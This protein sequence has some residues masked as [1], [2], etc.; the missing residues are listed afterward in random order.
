MAKSGMDMNSIASSSPHSP[1][2]AVKTNAMNTAD[3]KT[4]RIFIFSLSTRPEPK[5]YTR[6]GAPRC[7][8]RRFTGIRPTS[9]TLGHVGHKG[10]PVEQQ[11]Y[12]YPK[13]DRKAVHLGTDD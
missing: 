8:T 10:R 6:G 7:F 12:G 1:A 9:R 11:P 13:A 3:S 4:T 5:F 2:M